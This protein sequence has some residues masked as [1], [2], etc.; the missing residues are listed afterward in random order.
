[1]RF[2][3]YRSGW[4]RREWRWRFV[5]S[6]GRVIAISSEGYR[7]REDC[8][9]GIQLMREAFGPRAHGIKVD[10]HADH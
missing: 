4:F 7:N 5:S 8:M 1:M 6:N 9:N 3:V 10:I 2:E